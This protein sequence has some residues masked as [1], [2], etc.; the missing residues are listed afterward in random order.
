MCTL[1]ATVQRLVAAAL[2]LAG[3]LQSVS[4][5]EDDVT[6]RISFPHSEYI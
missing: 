3:S 6:P 5:G 1:A 2:L 4:D